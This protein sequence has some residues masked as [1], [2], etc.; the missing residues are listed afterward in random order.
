MPL[1]NFKGISLAQ[2]EYLMKMKLLM[3]LLLIACVLCACSAPPE[4]DPL[5]Q[6]SENVQQAIPED[7]EKQT[8]TEVYTFQ[9][10]NSTGAELTYHICLTSYAE[11]QSSN[12]SGFHADAVRGIFDP[13]TAQLEKEFAI[14]DHPAALYQLD[15]D[16]YLCCTS[17]PEA[18]V[19]LEYPAGSISEEDAIRII[20]SVYEGAN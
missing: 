15:D 11:S 19:V 5:K 14:S 1:S 12:I 13:D 10:T 18:S 17:S 20:Q 2:K 3:P 7:F 6:M 8:E 16:S 9:F 4:A